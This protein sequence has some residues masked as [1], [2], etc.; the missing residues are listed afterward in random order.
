MTCIVTHE[1]FISA[2]RLACGQENPQSVSQPYY[3]SK[4]SLLADVTVSQAQDRRAEARQKD[5]EYISK[6]CEK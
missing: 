2:K 6:R 5:I 4:S 3:A 1:K